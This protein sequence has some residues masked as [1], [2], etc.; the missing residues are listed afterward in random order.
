MD[1]FSIVGFMFGMMGFIFSMTAMAQLSALKKEVDQL[2]A[3]LRQ[4]D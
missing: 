4:G 1:S 3:R 2:K